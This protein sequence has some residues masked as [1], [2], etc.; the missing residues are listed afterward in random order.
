[1]SLVRLG[2]V[3]D[4]A[5]SRRRAEAALDL[6][7]K[8]RTW[9]EIADQ[10]GYRTPGGARHAVDRLLATTT[11]DPVKKRRMSVE[12]LRVI[13]RPLFDMY[14]EA[15]VP[16]GDPATA[17]ML[18]KELRALTVEEARLDDLYSPKRVELTASKSLAEQIDALR[19][20]WAVSPPRQQQH[21]LGPATIDA[22][23]IEE[24]AG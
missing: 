5:T 9:A 17:T 19:A 13:Q 4:H 3:S 12:T 18:A 7:V 8:K 11:T 20:Q 24:A 1:M 23:V 14:D 15:A 16:G 6:R 10:L 22:E 21:Q 2:P